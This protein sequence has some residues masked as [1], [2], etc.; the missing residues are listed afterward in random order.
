MLFRSP[1][2]AEALIQRACHWGI[3]Q[4][5]LEQLHRQYVR[6]LVTVALADGRISNSESRDLVNVGGWLGLDEAAVQTEITHAKSSLAFGS[7]GRPD[8]PTENLKGKSVCFT[9]ELSVTMGGQ[10]ITRE[11]AE[12][13]AR[14]AGMV[15]ASGVNKRLDF[16]V[17]ADRLSQ[18]GK[19]DKARAYGVPIIAEDVFW[20]MLSAPVD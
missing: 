11:M 18:S 15:V 5:G 9:G 6:Q 4:T 17:A 13:L 16:L 7:G 14:S 19:A 10:L 12:D 20:R 2:E 3:S 8:R 1:I